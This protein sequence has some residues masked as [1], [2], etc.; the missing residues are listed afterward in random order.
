MNMVRVIDRG[1]FN[2]II[3]SV[4][5]FLLKVV[6]ILYVLIIELEYYGICIYNLN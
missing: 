1:I 4:L 3:Y 2:V 5:I 6:L